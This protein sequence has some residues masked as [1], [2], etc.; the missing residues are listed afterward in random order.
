MGIGLNNFKIKNKDVRT[1]INLKHKKEKSKLKREQ[2]KEREEKGLPKQVPITLDAKREYDE[3]MK[4]D[5]SSSDEDSNDDEDSEDDVKEEPNEEAVNGPKDN[6]QMNK[7]VDD[8]SDFGA[9]FKDGRDPK[10]LITTSANCSRHAYNFVDCFSE[11]FEDVKF[12]K[13]KRQ[14]SMR[15]MATLSSNRGYTHLVVV[16]EDK[17]KINGMTFIALPEGPTYY[18]SVSSYVEGKKIA[19]HGKATSHIPEL[20]LKNFTTSLG[21]SVSN[22]FISLFPLRPNYE[23]RQVVTIHNQ[24]DFIFFRRH[25]YAFRSEEKAGLQELGPQFTLRLRRVQRGIKGEIEWEHKPS[26]DKEKKKFYM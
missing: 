11:L 14:Y 2:R 13:R 19:G 21:R 15:D 24:R 16:N 12:I 8:N 10:V 23:G 22:L 6:I 9:Y 26:M 7:N 17:K 1:Q 18:F 3:T 5:Y 4:L 20:I 25:R